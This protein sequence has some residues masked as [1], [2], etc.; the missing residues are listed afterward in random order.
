VFKVVGVAIVYPLI[1]YF[2]EYVER[3]DATPSRA[4]ANAHTIFNV[5][6]AI[7]FLP[8]L[9]LTANLIRKHYVPSTEKNRFGPKYLDLKSLE[10]PA[11]AFGNAQREF[12]RMAD[13]VNDI[14]KDVLPAMG[15]NDLDMIADLEERDDKIDILNREIRFYLAKISLEA[16]NREQ[17]ERQVELISLSNDIENV[18]DLVTRD[19]LP[20]AVKKYSG[21]FTFS[22]QGWMEIEDFHAKVCENFNLALVA[23]SSQNEEIARK[24]LRHCTHLLTIETQLKEKHI[25]RLNQGTRESIETS[26]M[27]LD[28]LAQLR[29]INGYIG[30]LAF[31]VVR[32]FEVEKQTR[33]Q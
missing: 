13:M 11:L 16:V 14:V 5:L 21:G 23:Y 12:L 9:G 31:A 27:H 33:S 3:I 15:K 26:S 20:L 10:T 4:I 22:P 1:P 28:L 29:Q 19:I 6:N 8:L 32:Y 24:V 2:I 25:G 30:N 7:L 18:A 17:A